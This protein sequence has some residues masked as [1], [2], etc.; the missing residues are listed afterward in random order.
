VD[1]P[2]ADAA[3]VP[4]RGDATF[5]DVGALPVAGPVAGGD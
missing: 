2:A 3:H 1:R 4:F 5:T